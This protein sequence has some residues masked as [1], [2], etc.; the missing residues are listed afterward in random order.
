MIQERTGFSTEM[1]QDGLVAYL[2][3]LGSSDLEMI[4][5]I[6]LSNVGARMPLSCAKYGVKHFSR[7]GQDEYYTPEG[8]FTKTKGGNHNSWY[9]VYGNEYDIVAQIDTDFVPKPTFLTKTL[10][11]FK[12]PL[13][14]FV[15]TPQVYGNINGSL[16]A[17][18]AAEQQYSFYG[19]LLQGLSGMNSSLLIGANH[20]IRVSA[21]KDVDHY[22]AHITEDLLTGM[23]LHAKGWKSVYISSP[24]A[25]GEG[26]NTWESYFSQQMRWAYGCT[27]ILLRHSPKLFTQMGFRRAIY[28]F[29]LQQHYFSG[30]AMALSIILLSIYFVLGIRAADVDTLLFFAFYSLILLICWLM[31]NWLQ[32]YHVYKQKSEQLLLAGTII[33]IASWPIWFLAFFCAIIGKKLNYKVTPKGDYDNSPISYKVFLPHLIFG[34]IPLAGLVSSFF[35]HRQSPIMLFW[36]ISSAFAM[37]SIPFAQILDEKFYALK[38]RLGELFESD[39]KSY[40]PKPQSTD[41]TLLDCLFLGLMVIF[42]FILYIGQLGFYS[43]D[44]QFLGSFSTSA[45][46]TFFGLVQIATTPNTQMRPI[47]NIYDAALYFLF[48][49]NPIGYQ[50]INGMVLIATIVLFYLVLKRLRMPRIIAISIP[51]IYSMLPNYATDRFWYAAYQANLSM[52]LFFVSLYAGIKVFYENSRHTLFWKIICIL[53]L[54]LS[55]L[56]YEVVVPL[57]LVN[58]FLFWN[59]NEFFGHKIVKKKTNP[60]N[61]AFIILNFIV[62]AYILVFKAIT[63]TRLGIIHFPDYFIYV[64]TSAINTN[65]LTLGVGLPI[66]VSRIY[67]QYFNFA[68]FMTAIVLFMVIFSFLYLIFFWHEEELPS[69]KWLGNLS[70]FGILVFF[71]GYAIFLT[72]NQVGFSPTG[73]E[74]RVAVAASIGIAISLIGLTGYICKVLLPEIFAKMVFCVL[75]ALM[76]SGY[77]IVT[78]TLASFWVIASKQQQQVLSSV[79]QAIPVIP[80]N[81]TLILDGVCPY[82]GPAIVFESQWDFRGALQATYHDPNVKA[83]VVT[84]RL[85]V[86]DNGIQTE[87]YTFP[88]AY[89]YKNLYIFNYPR[90]TVYPIS[91]YEDARNYFKEINPDRNNGCPQS[92]VGNGVSIF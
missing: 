60:K 51:L 18:G 38:N 16:I 47:Q 73:I 91:N 22:S 13:I 34:I 28:Y 61:A 72:N 44:W 71:L 42:T 49:T 29:F 41:N 14:A 5:E 57:I 40:S 1:D 9:E 25:I 2:Q 85:N 20:V 75:V 70:L 86:T 6:F 11:Y 10:G 81:T 87:I 64:I 62:L 33:N 45:N 77:F 56:S 63:T 55:A 52:L 69:R 50:I 92:T 27:D 36:A 78:D 67:N 32:R 39:P 4:Q 35:T 90:N 74:N 24:L 80:E 17:K 84:P 46:Q 43:D 82:I 12:D 66:I 19:T 83:D 8:K 31:S 23:K 89:D 37:L 7:F 59:P 21:L 30:V 58:A 68:I 53:G 79:T 65:Y 76:C 54:G 15:G 3:E 48:G 26:P 88:A